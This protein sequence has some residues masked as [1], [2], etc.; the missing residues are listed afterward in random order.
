MFNSE[1]NYD[2]GPAAEI[3]RG[4][5]V[6]RIAELDASIETLAQNPFVIE[7]QRLSLAAE[8]TDIEADAVISHQIPEKPPINIEDNRAYIGMLHRDQTANSPGTSN[9]VTSMEE[10]NKRSLSSNPDIT[11]IGAKA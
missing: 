3:I 11:D 4:M 7:G 6:G 5:E 2:Q 8:V 10:W 1:A 9:N